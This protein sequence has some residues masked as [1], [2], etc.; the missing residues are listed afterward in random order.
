M[1]LTHIENT[2]GSHFVSSTL[3][4]ITASYYGMSED[5]LLDIL[6]INHEV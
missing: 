5:E 4:I 2:H 3:R 1:L 6:T